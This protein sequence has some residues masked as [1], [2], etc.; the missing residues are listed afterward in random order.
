MDTP[1]DLFSIEDVDTSSM[2]SEQIGYLNWIVDKNGILQAY[3][4]GESDYS[5]IEEVIDVLKQGILI[6]STRKT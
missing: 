4:K 5:C 3:W 2:T 6:K 1:L